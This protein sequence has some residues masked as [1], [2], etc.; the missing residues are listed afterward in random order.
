[1]W[2]ECGAK[3]YIYRIEIVGF[4]NFHNF[5]MDFNDGLNVIVGANNSGKT[6]LLLA[7]N[8]LSN[9]GDI[10]AEDFNKNDL[11]C[12]YASLYKQTPP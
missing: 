9:P 6:G 7:I 1:M 2:K 10:G 4:R 3:L 8:L 12:Q 5:T 11:Q